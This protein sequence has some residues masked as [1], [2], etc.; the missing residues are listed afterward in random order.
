MS[1]KNWQRILGFWLGL[2]L[3][4]VLG[5]WRGQFHG[6]TVFQ[7]CQ[8]RPQQ[9]TSVTLDLA[10]Q[11]W[12][13]KYLQPHVLSLHFTCLLPESLPLTCRVQGFEQYYLTQGSKK[14]G[15][16]PELKPDQ[17]LK[18]QR[19]GRAAQVNMELALPR[20]Q[21]KQYA[22]DQGEIIFYHQGQYYATIHME[23]INS[24]YDEKGNKLK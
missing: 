3:V 7:G 8:L 15:E 12:I 19:K 17:E 22:V 9:V 24:Q 21:T 13:K 18:R 5:F 6:D 20:E 1:R 10:E 16:W 14:K 4:A 23:I 11:G 2:I